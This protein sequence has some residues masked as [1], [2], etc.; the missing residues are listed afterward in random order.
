MV[1]SSLF[2]WGRDFDLH[3][4]AFSGALFSVGSR[5]IVDGEGIFDYKVL[6]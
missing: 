3:T 5:R 2:C 4:D 1:G 6:L